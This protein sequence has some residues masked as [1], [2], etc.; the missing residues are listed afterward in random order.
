MGGFADMVVGYA[1][2]ISLAVNSGPLLEYAL[3]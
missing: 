2:Q 1:S 3:L